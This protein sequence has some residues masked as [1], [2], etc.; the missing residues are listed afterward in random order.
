[1]EYTE[2]VAVF[3]LGPRRV[4][5]IYISRTF[6]QIYH[7]CISTID[8]HGGL[9]PSRNVPDSAGEGTANLRGKAPAPHPTLFGRKKLWPL[10]AP[11]RRGHNNT[12]E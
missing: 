12:V 7:M 2:P 11:L 6:F 8:R 9:A 5:A 3:A 4:V 1:M 10:G